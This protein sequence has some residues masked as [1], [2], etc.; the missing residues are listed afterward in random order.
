MKT[1]CVTNDSQH[2]RELNSHIPRL[3]G[4]WHSRMAFTV[5]E[6]TTF[7]RGNDQPG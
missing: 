3:L 6:V 4:Y 2:S 1:L 5:E 7:F